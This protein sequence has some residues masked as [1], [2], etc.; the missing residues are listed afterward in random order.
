MEQGQH[1]AGA[2]TPWQNYQMLNL[3]TVP[4]I[5]SLCNR[6]MLCTSVLYTTVY[7]KEGTGFLSLNAGVW[8]LLDEQNRD[9]AEL[10]CNKGKCSKLS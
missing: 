8:H 1:R 5:L 7:R 3:G 10:V 6:A 2:K 9:S 4:T